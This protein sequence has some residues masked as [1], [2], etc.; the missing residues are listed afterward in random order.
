MIAAVLDESIDDR[1]LR[2]EGDFIDLLDP[3]L[4][5][6]HE[7]TIPPGQQAW[8]LDLNRVRGPEAMLLAAAGRV[9]N[10]N[11]S[12]GRVQY[13]LT[14]PEGTL[15]STRLRLPAAPIAVLVGGEPSEKT[16]WDGATRTLQLSHPAGPE[17]TTVE[18][19]WPATASEG[20]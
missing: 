18:I 12:N 2:L 14:A 7:V 4:P 3:A 17:P 10:W 5:V 20:R 9:E 6:R 16:V 19:T 11:L 8:L 15:A 1:P 13:E